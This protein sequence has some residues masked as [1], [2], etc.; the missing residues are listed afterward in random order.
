[1][2][3][4]TD[5]DFDKVNGVTT[6][7]N[8]LL[9]HVPP[10]V[11]VRIYTADARGAD[12]PDYLSLR[13]PGMPIPFYGEMRMY[14]PRVAD[15]IRHASADR[16]D[17]V[18]ITTPGPVG[19]AGIRVAHA[20]NLPLVGTFHTDLSAYTTMLSGSRVLGSVMREW[21]RATYGRCLR[22]LAASED[23]RQLLIRGRSRPERIGVWARG[24]DERAFSPAHRSEE[25]RR[26]WGASET[27]PALLYVG[28]VSREK[29]LDLLPRLHDRLRILGVSHQLVIVGHGPMHAELQARLPDAIFTGTLG[30]RDVASAFAS[31]DLFVFPSLTDTAGNVVLEAQASGLP[32]LVSDK[33]GPKENMLPGMSGHIVPGACVEAWADAVVQTL[34][35]RNTFERLR[36]GARQ[37]ALTR[38][39][40]TALEPLFRTYREVLPPQSADQMAGDRDTAGSYNRA[41]E[42]RSGA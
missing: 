10:G 8:E 40:D 42:Q 15:Y 18:H 17:V 29:G 24:V 38:T 6:T 25:L 1:V 30:R 33:G 36:A 39:W 41:A 3:I 31:A 26:A 2:A 34:G 20:L 4:F 7:L 27:R 13:S 19:V 22:V 28:R 16:I 14:L 5:N 21:L 12:R 9:R 11:A 35:H 32:V 37:Y 23:T